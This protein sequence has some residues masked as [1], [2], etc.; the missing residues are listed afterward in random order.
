MNG[1]DVRTEVRKLAASKPVHA[2]AGAGVLATE[3]LR[4]LP[5]LLAKWRS[6]ASVATLSNRATDY[7]HT[8]RTRASAGYDNLAKRGK[9]VLGGRAH[10]RGRTAVGGGKSR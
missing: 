6:E 4:E 3:R 10:P 8:A 5:T 9:K 1:I 7:M 2:V